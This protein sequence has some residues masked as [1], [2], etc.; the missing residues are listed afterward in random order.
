MHHARGMCIFAR[1]R[2]ASAKVF[3]RAGL[4][5]GLAVLPSR[6]PLLSFADAADRWTTQTDAVIGGFS[7][8]QLEPHGQSSLLWTGRTALESDPQRA[9]LIKNDQGKKVTRTGF[10]S[11]RTEVTD[12]QWELFDFDGL[13]VRMRA[14]ERSYVLNVRADNVL[15]DHRRDD[16]YQVQIAPFLDHARARA[17]RQHGDGK[18]L[19][20]VD[21]RI[22]WGAFTL[23]WRGYVQGQRSPPMHLGRLTHLGFLLADKQEGSFA[24]AFES[25]SA[26]RYEEW[27]LE[28]DDHVRRAAELNV[29][30]GYADMRD[31]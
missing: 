31:G 12:D 17:H 2:A 1:L 23:T 24:C 30:H 7:E 16:L 29:A 10:V 4:E 19:D 18:A 13:C 11:M 27:E 25:I 8:C 22:P 14:D 3:A 26:F 20:F 28:R 5:D 21:V 15:G 6:L 9:K